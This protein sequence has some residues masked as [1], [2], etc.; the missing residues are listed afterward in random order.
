MKPTHS[1][2]FPI[3]KNMVKAGQNTFGSRQMTAED[4]ANVV[5]FLCSKEAEMI[6][7]QIIIVDGGVTLTHQL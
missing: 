7:G 2:L 1:N 3:K 6:K 5:T 4:L